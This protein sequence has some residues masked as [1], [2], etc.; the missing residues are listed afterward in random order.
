MVSASDTNSSVSPAS[1]ARSSSWPTMSTTVAGATSP[2]K[3]QPKAA[4]SEPRVT[5]RPLAW[6][7]LM[8]ERWPSKFCSMVRFWLIARNAA[9]QH[10]PMLPSSCS[11]SSWPRARCRPRSFSQSAV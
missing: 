1:A 10:R 6:Y 4:I 7:I 8:M 5:G 3:L 2:W 9:E 11:R